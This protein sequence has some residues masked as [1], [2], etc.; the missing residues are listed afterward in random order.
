ML[1]ELVRQACVSC[2][3]ATRPMVQRQFSNNFESLII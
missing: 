2:A 1:K 3:P